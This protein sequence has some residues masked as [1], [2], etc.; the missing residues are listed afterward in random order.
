MTTVLQDLLIRLDDLRDARIEAFMQEH[1]VDM[2][3]VSPPESVHALD[4]DQLRKPEIAFWSAWRPEPGGDTLV[5]TGAL[6]RLDAHHAELKSMRTSTRLRGQGIARQLLNHLLHDARA[7][8]FAR[9]SLE[10]GTQPFFEPA[11]QLYFQHGFVE[12]GPFADYRLDPHSFFM[13]RAL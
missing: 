3:A 2:R 1:L 8:G 12:C 9:V 6:K 10:T 11:R 4:M 13:T 5:G 7:R